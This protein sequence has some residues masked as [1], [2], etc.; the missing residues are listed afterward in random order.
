MPDPGALGNVEKSYM[1]ETL[2][3]SDFRTLVDD[4][5]NQLCI[6]VDDRFD[7]TVQ[8]KG[9]DEG[10]EKL[11]MLVN[12]TLDASRRAMKQSEERS[13]QLAQS[14][15]D[16]EQFAYVASHDLQAP[17]RSI[18]LFCEL[19]QRHYQGKL[20]ATADD[21]IQH[22]VG[23]AARMR[24]LISDLLEYA[25]ID[26]GTKELEKVNCAEAVKEAIENLESQI[27]EC[28]AKVTS[29]V[30]PTISV[31]RAQLVR[32]FQ[33]L[34]GN[35]IKFHGESP[36]KVDVSAVEKGGEWIFEVRDNGI[37][38]P[39]EFMS[40]LFVLFQ[41]LHTEG[42]YKGTGLGLAICKKIVERHAGS[43]WVESPVGVGSRFFFSLPKERVFK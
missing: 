35:G 12:F 31:N 19:L 18:T 40:K 10:I 23:S 41:R 1:T 30:L 37:G 22:I 39:Q 38:I 33:N 26:Q 3:D 6:T 2:S 11:Q 34:I 5:A 15:R 16:L 29:D 24:V 42:Q 21:Y 36:P 13:R 8:V 43:I 4:L 27:E 7:F 14:N 17:L 32:L 28:Q 9:N 20:D 25:K